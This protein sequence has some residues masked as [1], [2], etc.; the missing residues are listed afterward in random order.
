VRVRKLDKNGDMSFGNGQDDFWRDVPDGPAQC[1]KTRLMLWT[2]EW[3]LDLNEGMPWNTQ[4]L[5]YYTGTTRDPAIRAR[6]LGTQGV[7][8]FT[9]YSSALDREPRAFSVNCLLD[10]VYGAIPFIGPI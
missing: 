9:N 10:T 8:G 1:V 4:V 2:G 6:I 3:F 7:K 5:G